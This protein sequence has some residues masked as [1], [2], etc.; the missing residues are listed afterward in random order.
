[1]VKSSAIE[2]V[3]MLFTPSECKNL[4]GRLVRPGQLAATLK[5][6]VKFK[7]KSMAILFT[8]YF[9]VINTKCKT[10]DF[11]H[12]IFRYI[13]GLYPN[14]PFETRN[15]VKGCSER[16]K[17]SSFDVPYMHQFMIAAENLQAYKLIFVC[18]RSPFQC[19]FI[20]KLRICC[21]REPGKKQQNHC[22][23][24]ENPVFSFIAVLKQFL[25]ASF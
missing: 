14:A 2:I 3:Q 21:R 7:K 22:F 4:P 20:T 19:D 24:L 17:T 25:S 1:M 10:P 12:V 9:Y 23:L 8:I 5:K 18:M 13:A 6:H 16:I 11:T 15:R